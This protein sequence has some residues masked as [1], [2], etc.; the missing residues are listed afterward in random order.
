MTHASVERARPVVLIVDDAK[1]IREM[2]RD[3]LEQVGFEVCG[4]EDGETGL[5][6]FFDRLPDLVFLDVE[7]SGMDGFAVCEEIRQSPQGANTPILMMTAREDVDSIRRAY[8]VGAT[9][10]T[11]K[12]VN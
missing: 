7:M 8:E 6:L 4:A 2:G 9:D 12:P 5:R 1:M 3:A 11:P 10:F